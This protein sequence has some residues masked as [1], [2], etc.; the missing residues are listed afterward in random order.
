MLNVLIVEPHDIA[1][2]GLRQILK[3]SRL[4]RQIEAVPDLHNANQDLLAEREWDVMLFSVESATGDEFLTIKAVRQQHARLAVLALGRHPEALLAVRALKAGASGYLPMDATQPQLLAAVNAI[5]KGKKY[6]PSDLVEVLAD[7]VAALL[8]GEFK[9][10]RVKLS[11]T[12]LGVL[13]EAMGVDRLDP[14]GV[15]FG[16]STG[17]VY[18]SADEG[19]SWR[20]LADHLPR[21]LSVDAITLD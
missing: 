20:L 4:A 8:M 1:R 15:Y 19:R 16:T 21:I 3:D 5:S 13:R 18:G 7:R 11:I 6:L 17:Q 10:P 14:V 2:A 12:K 9:A